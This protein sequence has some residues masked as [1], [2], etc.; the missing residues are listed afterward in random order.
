MAKSA[1]KSQKDKELEYAMQLGKLIQDEV[2]RIMEAAPSK[3]KALAL[4]AIMKALTVSWV[5]IMRS[6]DGEML[7]SVLMLL[8]IWKS[9]EEADLEQLAQGRM[10]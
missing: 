2:N 5:N 9:M 8:E 6:L 7:P 4:T 1:K 3:D 10:H